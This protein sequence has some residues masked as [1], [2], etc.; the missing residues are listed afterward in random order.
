MSIVPW[1]DVN[2]DPQSIQQEN[3]Q[4]SNYIESYLLKLV[5][6]DKNIFFELSPF[7]F[8]FKKYRLHPVL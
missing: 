1:W 8:H 7:D 5:V 3:S 4:E 2:P 6:Y